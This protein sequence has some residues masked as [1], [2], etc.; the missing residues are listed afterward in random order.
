MEQKISDR[1]YQD[2]QEALQGLQNDVNLYLEIATGTDYDNITDRWNDANSEF[3]QQL[4]HFQASGY[5]VLLLPLF[6]QFVNLHLA[7][8]RDGITS[9]ATWG[10]QSSTVDSVSSD[11]TTY[12]VEYMQWVDKY[13]QEGYESVVSSTKSDDHACQPFMAVNQ[14]V[15]V[16]T[17]GVRDYRWRWGYISEAAHGAGPFTVYLKREI[18]SDPKGTCDDSGNIV[19]PLQP[20]KFPTEIKVWTGSMVDG[21]Q[22]TYPSAGGPDHV[23]TTAR[24]GDQSGGALHGQVFDTTNNPVIEA[25]G[26]A[27]DALNA[28][29]FKF[30]DGTDTGFMGGGSG[31][32]GFMD[33]YSGHQLSSIHI[34]GESHYYQ[35]ADCVVYGF[36]YTPVTNIVGTYVEI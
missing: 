5:E 3:L 9:G 10:W 4:P 14:Y 19:I 17:L 36:K 21:A 33:S 27:G 34:N 29:R 11:M 6:A 35:C 12:T 32:G 26:R 25:G 28:M 8:L 18:Y 23:T 31:S 1:V 30:Q 2:V 22:V 13:Y 16:M 7:L 15:R 20:T 24:M